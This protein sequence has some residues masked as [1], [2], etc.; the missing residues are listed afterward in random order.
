MTLLTSFK[1]AGFDRGV[2]NTDH[3]VQSPSSPVPN[4]LHGLSQTEG[5]LGTDD[6]RG[7]LSILPTDSW[8]VSPVMVERFS[9]AGA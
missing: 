9:P 7:Q 4:T 6:E 5:C 2:L 1:S 8:I 3:G